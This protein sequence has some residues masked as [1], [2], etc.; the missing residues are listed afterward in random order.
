M[1]KVRFYLFETRNE[2]QVESTCRL[3]RKILRQAQRIWIYSPNAELQQQ[4]D[5]QLWTFDPSSF[6]AHGIDDL[7]APVCIS[8]QLPTQGQWILINLSVNSINDTNYL[9]QIIEIVENNES[10]K[11][12]GRE[13]FKSYRDLGLELNTYKL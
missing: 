1:A 2:R 8:A 7:H 13:K 5:Q 4:I 9:E 6:I 11:H 3:C 12:I 10:A